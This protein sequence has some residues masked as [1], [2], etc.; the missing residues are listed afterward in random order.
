MFLFTTLRLTVFNN[1][2]H[3]EPIDFAK[4]QISSF[5]FFK[6]WL[7]SHPAMLWLRSPWCLGYKSKGSKLGKAEIKRFEHGPLPWTVL[8]EKNYE[9]L[10]N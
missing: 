6:S 4:V 10:Q 8:F 5:K 7:R 3:E 1:Y 2:N 9:N